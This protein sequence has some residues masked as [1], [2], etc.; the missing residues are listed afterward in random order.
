[1]TRKAAFRSGLIWSSSWSGAAAPVGAS[2]SDHKNQPVKGSEH[3][4]SDHTALGFGLPTMS[5]DT[6]TGG[7]AVVS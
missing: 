2:V 5:E 6:P 7:E 4:F 3:W 1:M